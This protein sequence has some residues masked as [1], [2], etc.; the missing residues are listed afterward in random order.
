MS[1][2]ELYQVAH[3]VGNFT[4]RY[5]LREI[6]VLFGIALITIT[7]NRDYLPL[8]VIGARGRSPRPN[9]VGHAKGLVIKDNGF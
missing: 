7:A 4:S 1:E 9:F 3:S 8:I 2:K 5:I 6:C